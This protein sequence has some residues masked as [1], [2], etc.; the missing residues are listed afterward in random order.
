MSP[1]TNVTGARSKIG[2]RTA[3]QSCE[4]PRLLGSQDSDGAPLVPFMG[5]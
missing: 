2:L 1:T 5:G 4:R 3:I